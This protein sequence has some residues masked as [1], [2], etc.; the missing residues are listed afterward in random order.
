MLNISIVLYRP[1]FGQLQFICNKVLQSPLVNKLYLVD[2]SPVSMQ[3]IPVED[4]RVEYLFTGAN[5]GYGKAHNIALRKSLS[6][7][8]EYHLVMNCDVQLESSVIDQLYE[9]ISTHEQVGCIMPKVYYPDGQVQLLCKLLP[10]PFDMFG[11]RFLPGRWIRRQNDRY[12]L[13]ESGYNKIMSVPN[14]SG[15]FLM[16]RCSALKEVGMFDE[17]YFMYAEDMDLT[18]RL[19]EHYETVFYPKCTIVHEHERAS[20]FFNHLLF[21]HIG[22]ICKYFMKW[23]WFFRDRNRARVNKEV[24]QKYCR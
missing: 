2:N 4:K 18:R 22:S 15:C 19:H 16:L 8:V 7:G 12:Q 14:L 1:H 5:L 24:Y 11:R 21:V 20:Y 13:V 17:R 23:G 9:Y 10:T 3:Q 6:A